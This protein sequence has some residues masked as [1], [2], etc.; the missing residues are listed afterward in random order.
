M[1]GY[2]LGNPSLLRPVPAGRRLS[3][4]VADDGDVDATVRDVAHLI[5]E[6]HRASGRSAEADGAASV[7]ATLARWENNDTELAAHAELLIDGAAPERVV[8]LARAY[9]NGRGRL[10]TERIRDGRAVVGPGDL[11]ADDIFVLD[12]GPHILDDFEAG[13]RLP[14]GDGLANIASLA[15]DLE[16][17]GAPSLAARL[18]SWYRKFAGDQWP[19]SLAH[20]HIAFRA[21]VRAK[22]A[23]TDAARSGASSAPAADALLALAQRHLEAARVRLVLI[24]GV[25]D[26]RKTALARDLADGAGWVVES[27]EGVRHELAEMVATTSFAHPLDAGIYAPTMVALTYCE[28]LHRAE[29][30]LERGESV[31]LEATWAHPAWRTEAHHT[32]QHAGAHIV[33]FRCVAL[34]GGTPDDAR[35][36]EELLT[37]G[38]PPW[39]EATDIDTADTAEVALSNARRLS[40]VS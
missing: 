25:L 17:L 3:V 19:A 35:R 13:R 15:M 32:A 10:I 31:V 11:T 2:S 9:L 38:F 28:L 8:A 4:L 36:V 37:E 7:P 24:G 16:W 40:T 14:C 29:D 39:P 21:H 27:S 22:I 23:V 34:H 5:A 1:D 33:S 12:D 18:L 26:T 30:L 20:H 6:L